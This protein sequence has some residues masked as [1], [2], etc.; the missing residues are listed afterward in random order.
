MFK[1]PK[2]RLTA[3][4]I[5]LKKHY[6]RFKPWQYYY[7]KLLKQYTKN[8]IILD[9]GCGKGGIITQVKNQ[10]KEIIGV[11][12]DATVFKSNQVVD[13]KIVASLDK[14]PLADNI[15]DTAV[16]TFVIEHVDNPKDIFKEIFRILVPG[17]YFIFITTNICNPVIFFSKLL[18]YSVHLFLREKLLHKSDEGTHETYYQANTY[19]KLEEL[20]KQVGFKGCEVIKMGNPEYLAFSKITLLPAVYFEKLIDNEYLDFLKM[21]LVGIFQK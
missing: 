8:K 12:N 10:V 9:A 13:N 6:P 21:Y 7:L 18:P 16:A 19:S 4:E 3:L 15:I 14:I 17:G 20:S 11:D 2:D 1:N 5:T